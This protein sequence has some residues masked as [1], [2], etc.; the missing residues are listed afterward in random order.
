MNPSSPNLLIHKQHQVQTSCHICFVHQTAG[1][2][3]ALVYWSIL[4]WVHS[5]VRLVICFNWFWWFDLKRFRSSWSTGTFVAD[6][7]SC[8]G[9]MR[10][11]IGHLKLLGER[12]PR[13]GPEFK[14]ADFRRRSVALWARKHTSSH[15]MRPC[16]PENSGKPHLE[17][18]KEF[19]G[20]EVKVKQLNYITACIH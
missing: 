12:S 19:P 8:H 18:H 14:D 13:A 17:T 16:P 4:G 7:D 10:G 2:T 9:C 11:N 3:D 20:M 6:C 5:S 15:V 1:C